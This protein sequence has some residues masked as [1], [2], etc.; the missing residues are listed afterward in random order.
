MTLV[1]CFSLSD[2]LAIHTHGVFILLTCI[3]IEGNFSHFMNIFQKLISQALYD[4]NIS[5]LAAPSFGKRKSLE[6]FLQLAPFFLSNI[7]FRYS[8]NCNI[9]TYCNGLSCSD[10]VPTPSSSS[11]LISG[12][13]SLWPSSSLP[14]SLLPVFSL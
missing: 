14:T 13:S 3:N 12:V 4:F 1:S 7:I 5:P 10:S 6:L 2:L 8:N 11:T 9:H